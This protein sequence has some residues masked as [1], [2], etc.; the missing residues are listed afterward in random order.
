[1][2]KSPPTSLVK[3]PPTHGCCTPSRRPW[4]EN[5]LFSTRERAEEG[6]QKLMQAVEGGLG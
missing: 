2:E 1:M 6:K 4:D 3:K 5:Y